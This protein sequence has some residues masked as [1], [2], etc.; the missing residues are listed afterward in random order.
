MPETAAAG[1]YSRAL[2]VHSGR[3]AIGQSVR[4]GAA[5]GRFD[6]LNVVS[7][8][9]QVSTGTQGVTNYN[10]A[11]INVTSPCLVQAE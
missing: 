11:S 4:A 6:W 8:N 10:P 9:V 1:Q 3:A 2:S 5:T 7:R